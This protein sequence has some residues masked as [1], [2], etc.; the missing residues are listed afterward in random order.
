MKAEYANQTSKT[1][2]TGTTSKSGQ[3]NEHKVALPAERTPLCQRCCGL[4]RHLQAP[5]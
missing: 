5:L 2:S 1:G 4:Q 3:S